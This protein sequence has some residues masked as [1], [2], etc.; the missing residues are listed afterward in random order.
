MTKRTIAIA[1][2]ALL[3]FAG[4]AYAVAGGSAPT[5]ITSSV[6]DKLGDA[7]TA[8]YPDSTIVGIRSESGGGYEVEVRKSDGTEVHVSLDGAYKI[9]GTHEGG[10]RG[11][12]GRG[13]GPMGGGPGGHR[14]MHMDTAAL[15]KSLG[16]S[17]SKLTAALDKVR[18]QLKPSAGDRPQGTTQPSQADRDARR[19]EFAKALAK[20]LDVDA[21]K[22]TKA[23]EAQ[24]PAD[25]P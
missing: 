15:A 20:E 3:T 21:D 6:T 5:P 8:K 1:S 12:K 19:D 9:T 7:I 2:A 4:G 14:G 23:L 22:V 24:R 25:R 18:D 17:E 13:M 10:M 16:V 11:E